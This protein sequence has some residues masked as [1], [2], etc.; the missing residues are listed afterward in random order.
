MCNSVFRALL[1]LL[2]LGTGACSSGGDQPEDAATPAAAAAVS[3]SGPQ[4]VTGAAPPAANGF[5]A[6]IVLEPLDGEAGTPQP[7]VPTMDQVQQTFTPPVLFVR[8]GQPVEFTNNDDVLH[9]IRV[10]NDAT[11]S[12]AFNISIPNGETF[13][14]VFQQD[15]FYDVGCDIHPAMSAQIF[16]TTSPYAVNAAADG[17]FAIDNVP[18]GKYR[19]IVYAGETKIE[20][21]ITVEAGQ[22]PVDLSR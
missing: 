19:A 8:T 3:T 2:L 22:K 7:S 20:R 21:E 4:R 14:F 5:A 1:G 9:N 17:Q 13:R 15:G 18:M 12:S 6:F 16:S 10:R 11:K